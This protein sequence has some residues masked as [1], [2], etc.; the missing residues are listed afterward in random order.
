M[1]SP[2]S[3]RFL[4]TPSPGSRAL[5]S[6]LSDESIWRRLRDAGFDEESIKRRDKAALIAYIAKLE[7]EIFDHQH[8]MGLLI[9]ER[10]E[11]A[12]KHEQVKSSAESAE[13]RYKCEQAAHSSAL[14]EAKKR[15]DS[16]KKALGVE[17]E[18]IANIEKTLRE[19]RAES[20]ETK[21]AAEIKLTEARGM[22][23]DAQK[24]F[25]E[26]EAKLHAAESLQE[27]A[28]RYHRAAERT[29]QEVKA[30]ED[31]LRRRTTSFNSDCESKEKELILE[32]QSLCER[33]KVLQQGQERLLDAQA[34]LNQREDYIFD[35][36]QELDRLEK[37]LEAL[38]ASVEKEARDLNKEKSNLELKETS[39]LTREE[40]VIEKEN[41]LNKKEQELLILQEQHASKE[42]NEIKKLLAD[43]ETELKLRKSEVEVDLD[44]KRKVVEDEIENKRRAWE[45]KEV[46]LSQREDVI[47]ERE[48]DLEV[49]LR[50]LTDR[51]KDVAERLNMV[52][53]K[54]K[55]I[56]AAEEEVELQKIFLQKEK[57]EIN[58]MKLDLQKTI[59]SLED[60]K[61]QVDLAEE[62]LETLKRETNELM[63]LEMKLKE[64]IDVVRSQKLEFVAEADR[65][66]AEKAKFETEW[67]SI[68]E[69]REEL[70][71]EAECIA[72]ERLAISQ[73][74]KDERDSLKLEKNAMRDQHKCDIESLRLEREAFMR[75]MEQERSEWF[76]KI[77]QERADFLLDVEMRKRELENRLDKRHEEIESYLK[78]RERE[79]EQKTKTEL[80]NIS[81]LKE[82][83]A[84][85]MEHVASEFKRLESE[86]IEISWDREQRDKEW[87]E[88]NN[89]IEEL[90]IQRKKLEEQRELLHADRVKIHAQ[91]EHLK[92]L[93]DL[94][95]ISDN[96][97][98]EEM[99]QANARLSSRRKA[100][101]KRSLNQQPVM[102]ASQLDLHKR[103][104]VNDG[105][106]FD[107]P[108]KQ[109]ID[110]VS[111][112]NSTPFAWFKRCADLIFKH[113]PEKLLISSGERS[114]I[115]D[116]DGADWRA[117][118]HLNSSNGF[119]GQVSKDYDEKDK[120]FSGGLEE[121]KVILEVPSACEE[122][123]GAHNLEPE[124]E[125]SAS[126]NSARSLSEQGLLAGKR[127]RSKSTS[128]HD[129]I[130]TFLERRQ[131][132]KKRKQ[133]EDGTPNPSE[134]IAALGGT[135]AE[136]GVSS[137]GS[138][139]QEKIKEIIL[140]NG[141]QVTQHCQAQQEAI[142]E[143]S[144]QKVK[145]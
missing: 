50:A 126:E 9:L 94:K 96:I 59:G 87:A 52:D 99:E 107:S 116:H 103:I 104:D 78:E 134:E 17:K 42:S 45:L 10:K 68:D 54:E 26:A 113:S 53:E 32:R 130:D 8:H 38:K 110:C 118:G 91:I 88:L 117:A 136:N 120:T 24:K 92:K 29:L 121:P 15:E 132:N 144:G 95:I 140:V 124:T 145:N 57:E 72:A 81:S 115:S 82:T 56:N 2:R 70:H 98:I 14:A 84:K 43:Q 46:D 138:K 16:L 135:C 19:M 141:G 74:L 48:H 12:S 27:E 75:E 22:A 128:S 36:S 106:V 122:V 60:K 125:T 11:W 114:P 6:P 51:E 34:L 39:L 97:A 89:S 13:L 63:I 33:Q 21:V 139:M 3:E 100:N 7:A 37:E 44:R 18:C 83:V 111:H 102:R 1:A 55:N 142:S 62:N 67:E 58:N 69:K 105:I 47:M 90:K 85:E 108:S 28:S 5:Q 65:L 131:N 41:S 73:F 80:H 64:E 49:Q 79:F 86:R 123:K 40:A 143:E 23:E 25:T 77:Q 71:R 31:D 109:E 76:G 129:C 93:E 66:K 4:I 112:S 133:Q 101:A 20:A 137:C 119:K 127:R 30:R 61:K 35:R